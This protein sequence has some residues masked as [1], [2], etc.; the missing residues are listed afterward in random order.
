MRKTKSLCFK[1]IGSK[2]SNHILNH[3]CNNIVSWKQIVKNDK[4]T[5]REKGHP[6]DSTFIGILSNRCRWVIRQK[7]LEWFQS[8]FLKFYKT[9]KNYLLFKKGPILTNPKLATS[10]HEEFSPSKVTRLNQIEGKYPTNFTTYL[11]I[12]ANKLSSLNSYANT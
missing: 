12:Y 4:K 8:V 1:R 5:Y 2:V 7:L 3:E 9:N 6:R 10:G 11:T